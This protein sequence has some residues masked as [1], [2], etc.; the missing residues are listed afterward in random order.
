MIVSMWWPVYRWWMMWHQKHITVVTIDIMIGNQTRLYWLLQRSKRPTVDEDKYRTEIRF[1]VSA[2]VY[3]SDRS[4]WTPDIAK[5]LVYVSYKGFKIIP[6]RNFVIADSLLCLLFEYGTLWWSVHKWRFTRSGQFFFAQ[7]ICG[8]VVGRGKGR[9]HGADSLGANGRVENGWCIIVSGL[10][11]TNWGVVAP[12]AS[13]NNPFI[14][15][16]S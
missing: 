2:H 9:L 13:V 6:Y 10:T 4:L 5:N 16:F 11:P 12:Y 3:K 8:F 1:S 7:V 14:G 15:I